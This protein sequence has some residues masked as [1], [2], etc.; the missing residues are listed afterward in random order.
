M[1]ELCDRELVSSQKTGLAE[2]G[3]G[4]NK[5]VKIS[6]EKKKKIDTHLKHPF[7]HFKLLPIPLSQT[8][9]LIT[10]K[11][12]INSLNSN[13]AINNNEYILSSPLSSQL[14]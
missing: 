2:T 7:H 1:Q 13:L 14:P 5:Q 4:A 10:H 8:P 3:K 11:K 6:S 9:L 12:P